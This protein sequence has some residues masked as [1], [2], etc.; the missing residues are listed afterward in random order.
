MRAELYLSAVLSPDLTEPLSCAQRQML[1]RAVT[2]IVAL[3][4]EGGVSADQMVELLQAGL[5]VGELLQ[6]LTERSRAV[7]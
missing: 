3:G 5:T 6:Y 2:K 4:E 7:S 1:Q